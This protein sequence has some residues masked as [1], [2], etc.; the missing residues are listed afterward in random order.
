MERE[1]HENSQTLHQAWA[2]APGKRELVR[3][4]CVLP[5]LCPRAAKGNCHWG[6]GAAPT[7]LCYL[8]VRSHQ[9]LFMYRSC[10]KAEK[11]NY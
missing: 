8:V 9:L 5:P 3:V 11:G 4:G 10:A 2:L 1:D 6:A 7:W